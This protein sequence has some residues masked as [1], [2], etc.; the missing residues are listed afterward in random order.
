MDPRLLATITLLPQAATIAITFWVASRVISRNHDRVVGGTG[1]L[2]KR[3][4]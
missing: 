3:V 1:D 2:S 4:T